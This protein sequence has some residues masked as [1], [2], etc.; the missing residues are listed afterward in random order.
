M[1]KMDR[2]GA[3]EEWAR[4]WEEVTG[5]PLQWTPKTL[6]QLTQGSGFQQM[7]TDNGI[8]PTMFPMKAEVD[9]ETQAGVQERADETESPGMFLRMN[10]VR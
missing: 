6:D 3:V 2:E 5:N 7:L 10:W 4:T 8:S 9:E 1:A